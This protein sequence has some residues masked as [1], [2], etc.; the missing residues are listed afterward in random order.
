M[1][2]N[3]RNGLVLWEQRV[4]LPQ[5]RSELERMVDIDASPI[6]R[7]GILYV[8]SY[9]GRV[10]AYNRATGR[11]IWASDTS[12]HEDMVLSG[13][14]L[15]ISQSD[16]RVTAYDA[17]SGALLWENDQLLRRRITGPQVFGDYV[18][19]ADFKGYLHVMNRADGE[20]VA[21]RRLDRKGIRASMLSDEEILYVYGNRGRL[22]ALRAEP[23]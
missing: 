5:G 4:A 18:A 11:G 10:A 13:N 17:N 15:F 20:F 1:A 7:D 8:A 16:S 6:L 12:T 19:V 22:Y 9:Q 23:R 2:F 21:R 3:P 14:V